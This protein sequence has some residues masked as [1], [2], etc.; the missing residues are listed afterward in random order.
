[1]KKDNRQRLFEMMN[2][3]GGMTLTEF[4]TELKYDEHEKYR[5]LIEFIGESQGYDNFLHTTKTEENAKSICQNGFRFEQFQKTTDYIGNVDALVYM[6]YVRQAY[7]NFTVI[8]QISH[9]LQDYESI[10]E[11]TTDD[12]DNEIFILPPQYIKGYYNR[13]TKE[14]FPNQLFKK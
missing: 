7:G 9:S 1:V 11:K 8:I 12:E 2:K 13:T 6:L 3:V 14:I 10:S 5:N 4:S